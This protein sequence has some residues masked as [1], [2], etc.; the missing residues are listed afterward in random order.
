MKIEFEQTMNDREIREVRRADF[1]SLLKSA[2]LFL[3]LAP[4]VWYVCSDLRI[5]AWITCLATSFFATIGVVMI[6]LIPLIEWGSRKNTFIKRAYRYQIDE[7]GLRYESDHSNGSYDWECFTSSKELNQTLVIV[8]ENGYK[9]A[10]SKRCLGE[11]LPV[12]R[13]FLADR[14]PPKK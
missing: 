5:E 14:F 8:M 10:L 1:G 11:Y 13:C 4:V 6:C 2:A 9:M 12:L 7:K 3:F